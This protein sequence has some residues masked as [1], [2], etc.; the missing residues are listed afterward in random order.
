VA[1]SQEFADD[2]VKVTQWKAFLR[3]NRL[4]AGTLAEVIQRLHGF[5]RSTKQADFWAS[6]PSQR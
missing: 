4:E 1:L 2:V 6:V 3:K 5:W